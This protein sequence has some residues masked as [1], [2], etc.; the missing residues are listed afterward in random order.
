MVY[1][2]PVVILPNWGFQSMADCVHARKSVHWAVLLLFMLPT[3]FGLADFAAKQAFAQE[4]DAGAP[5]AAAGV[6]AEVPP[7]SADFAGE[8]GNS[9]STAVDSS[10]TATETEG[11]LGSGLQGRLQQAERLAVAA[12]S[13]GEAAKVVVAPPTQIDLLDLA[14]RGGWLMLPIAAMSLIVVAFGLE[15]LLGLRRSKIV[16][17]K[18]IAGLGRLASRPE[19][20]DPR[21]AYRLCQQFPSAASRVIRTMLLKVGRPHNE[22]EHAISE[23]NDREATRLYTNVR[24]LTLAAGVTPL[25]GLL[26]T[27]W[28]MIQAFFRTANLPIEGGANRAE[29]LADGIYV[30]LVTTFAGLAVAIPAAVMAHHFEGRILRLLRELDESLLGLLPQLEPYE[31]RLRLSREQLEQPDSQPVTPVVAGQPKA[32]RRPATRK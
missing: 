9:D 2:Y 4:G 22:L 19:G 32:R 29:F 7:P 27:V 30:A 28:G 15:R 25:L 31:G 13:E 20:F 1:P 12:T 10:N 23:A 18:L 3:L 14:I 11:G 6:P 17:H 21:Q 24:W 26:G 8:G 16:P 5:P